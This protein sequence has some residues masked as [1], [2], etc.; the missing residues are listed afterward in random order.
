M[1]KEILGAVSGVS[2]LASQLF[3][4]IKGDKTRDQ[5]KQEETIDEAEQAFREALRLGNLPAANAA[6]DRLWELRNKA[7]ATR[8]K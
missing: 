4:Y 1:V 6:I 2:A 7:A 8:A 5:I 3:R